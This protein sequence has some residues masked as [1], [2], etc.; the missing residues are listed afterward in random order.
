MLFSWFNLYWSRGRE[1]AGSIGV[2]VEGNSLVLTYCYTYCGESQ[3]VKERVYLD[4][5]RCNYGGRRPWFLC[6]GC[7]RRV[8]ILVLGG[9]LF[10][11]PHC[12]RLKY[13][14]QLE[15][16]LDTANRKIQK[17]KNRL[18][19][20]GLHQRTRDRLRKRLMEAE[21]RADEIFCMRAARFAPFK[22]WIQNV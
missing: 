6:P 12:Y 14:C 3:D 1:P 17:L 20:K 7:G 8:G 10:A 4:Y 5:T 15:T 21:I 19:R 16:K 22:D 18:N 9:K 2:K 11:C 13:W